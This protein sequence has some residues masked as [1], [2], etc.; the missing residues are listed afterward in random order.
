MD[1]LINNV[2]ALPGINPIDVIYNFIAAYI[3]NADVF[4]III[5]LFFVAEVIKFFSEN[6]NYSF[7]LNKK[8]YAGLIFLL[9]G[10]LDWL[11]NGWF[12]DTREFFIR[13]VL[14][15]SFVFFIYYVFLKHLGEYIR[16]KIQSKL[17]IEVL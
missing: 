15:W 3:F 11:F 13:L 16:Q 10:L 17:K 6:T 12:T 5:G 9:A 4:Y 1:S 7:E 2:Q 8:L 14:R